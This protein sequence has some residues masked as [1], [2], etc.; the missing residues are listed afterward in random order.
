MKWEL[1]ISFDF[2]LLNFILGLESKP[3]LYPYH[4]FMEHQ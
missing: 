1:N 3:Y 2:L 4:Y